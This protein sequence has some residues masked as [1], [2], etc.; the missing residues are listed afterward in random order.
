MLPVLIESDERV[1]VGIEDVVRAAV[2]VVLE[3]EVTAIGDIGDPGPVPSSL[4]PPQPAEAS[5]GT[6]LAIPQAISSGGGISGYWSWL[7]LFFAV[8]WLATLI[9]ALRLRSSRTANDEKRGSGVLAADEAAVLGRLRR[10]IAR[11]SFRS[12]ADGGAI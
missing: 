5:P 12:K 4:A 8:L 3:P 7:T 1:E 10:K 9:A 6:S 2:G 11:T